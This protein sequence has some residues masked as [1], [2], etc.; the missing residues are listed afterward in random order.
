MSEPGGTAALLTDLTDV[1]GPVGVEADA[2]SMVRSLRDNS[3]LSPLLT[4][5]V[6][7]R[8]RDDGDTL[9]IAAVV[10]PATEREMIDTL[11]VLARHRTPLTPRG[12]GTSNFGFISPSRGGVVLDLRRLK[13]PPVHAEGAVAAPAGVLQG[14][15]ESTAAELGRQLT[16]LTT[17]FASAT[18]GGWVAGGHVGLGSSVYGS[19]WDD[20]IV[21]LRVVTVE[22]TPRVL[23]LVGRAADPLIHTAGTVGVITEVTMPTVPAREWEEALLTFDDFDAAARFTHEVSHDTQWNHRVVAAQEPALVPAFRPLTDVRGDGALVLA[24]I[25][26]AQAGAFAALAAR[27]GGVYVPWQRWGEGARPSL[28]AMVY[29]H[30]MLWVKKRFSSAA[31]L[32][33]YFDAAHPEADIARLK[34]HF[35]DGVLL[36]VKYI[37]SARLAWVFGQPGAPTL[38]AAVVTVVDGGRPGAVA[39]VLAFCDANGIRYQNPHASHLE[40]SGMFPDIAEV[41]AC[42]AGIDPLGLCNPRKLRSTDPEV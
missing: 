7:Q 4:E 15:L 42:K 8:R 26:A 9:G 12:T 38:P 2:A 25:D 11:S 37:R 41:L 5:M 40:D 27:H 23:E 22:E 29:G 3:W 17:T 14:E 39:E 32:H 36:E 34:Q 18:V 19:T 24:I 28:A 10:A 13:G 16:L 20:N 33:V 6:E 35:G 1:L 31:F 21:G 30:R